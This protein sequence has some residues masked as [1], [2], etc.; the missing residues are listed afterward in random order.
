MVC[1]QCMEKLDSLVQF[2]MQAGVNFELLLAINRY[3]E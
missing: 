2:K 3:D 1:L